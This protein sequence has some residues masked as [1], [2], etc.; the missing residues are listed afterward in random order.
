MPLES[1]YRA[2]LATVLC[3]ASLCAAQNQHRIGVRVVS[4]V[5]EFYDRV[6]G[7]TFVPR[8]NNLIR[9]APQTAPDGSTIQY[10]STLNPGSYDPVRI[11]GELAAMQAAGY[12]VVHIILNGCCVSGSLVD[13]VDPQVRGLNQAYIANMVDFADRAKSHNIYVVFTGEDPPYGY[14]FN[15][16]YR[17]YNPTYFGYLNTDYMTKDGVNG[18]QVLWH[19]LI[20]SAIQQGMPLDAVMAWEPR[21]E[22]Y[23]PDNYPPLSLSSGLVTTSLSGK[24]Y[25]MGSAT[26]RRAAMDDN[27]PL[28]LDG[29]RSQ[30]L[31]DDP[32]AL[33]TVGFFWPQ[34]PNPTR[35]GDPREIYPYPAVTNSQ[36]DFVSMSVYP[37]DTTFANIM[38]NFNN[39]PYP[40]KPAVFD[41][42]GVTESAYPSELGAAD[43]LESLQVDSCSFNI[44]GWM[45]WTFD[46]EAAEQTDGPFWS[47]STGNGSVGQHLSPAFRMDPCK[48]LSSVTLNPSATQ[49]SVGQQLVL[50]STVSSSSQNYYIP[51]G[52]VQFTDENSSLATTALDASGNA[53]FSTTGLALGPHWIAATYA[54]DSKTLGST[55]PEILVLVT[56]NALTQT[57]VTLNTSLNPVS[58]HQSGT[59]TAAVS[60]AS[61]IPG[62]QVFLVDGS[63]LAATAT[64]DNSGTAS[65]DASQFS[66]GSHPLTAIYGGS[67]TFN[68]NQ[69]QILVQRRSPRPHCHGMCP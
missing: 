34:T 14:Y 46:T 52:S 22:L 5:G 62:G 25:D 61:G 42:Y 39:L 48:H 67:S 36:L 51:T 66:V 11:E 30:I 24:T 7:Q 55:T 4:G 64:L 9:L 32:T 38:Q 27:L 10:H 63:R 31:A 57:S 15:L 49:V 16:V 43:Y 33:V 41:E 69:S 50:S 29:V 56:N 19:D 54:G 18:E 35:V 13:P 60:S 21:E 26:S 23:F 47:A 28:W 59:I 68:V 6:T 17:E 45:L 8:G 12:N 3:F 53:S 1:R 58:L 2:L 20:T 65:F 40:A 44:K 37:F